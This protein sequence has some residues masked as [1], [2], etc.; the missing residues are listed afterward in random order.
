MSSRKMVI[1]L[2]NNRFI[3]D[4]PLTA[5]Q[6]ATIYFREAKKKGQLLLGPVEIRTLKDAGYIKRN[7]NGG[8]DI[9]KHG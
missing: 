1:E 4:Q 7:P 5:S 2:V 3:E 9:V 6:I 8:W